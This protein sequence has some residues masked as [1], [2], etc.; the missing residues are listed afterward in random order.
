MH[1]SIRWAL[2]AVLA[3]A[4][5]LSGCGFRRKKYENPIGKDTEQPDK[6]LFDKAISDIEKGRYE[7]ARLTLN[8]LHEHVRH[9]R[10]HGQGQTRHRR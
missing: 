7:V 10:V 9:Q 8:T 3:V 5:L 4:A 2:V 1:K 6:V